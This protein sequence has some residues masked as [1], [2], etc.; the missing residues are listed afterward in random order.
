MFRT[1]RDA[2]E[3]G[4]EGPKLRGAELTRM[5][6]DS[7]QMVSGDRGDQGPFRDSMK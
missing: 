2:W 4:R 7:Q 5:R 6:F 3:A 1:S